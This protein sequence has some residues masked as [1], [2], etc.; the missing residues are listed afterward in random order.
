MLPTLIA[1][2]VSRSLSNC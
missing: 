1:I 2:S